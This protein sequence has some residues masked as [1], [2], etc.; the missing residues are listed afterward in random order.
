MLISIDTRSDL[1]DELRL[2]GEFLLKLGGQSKTEPLGSTLPEIVASRP[3]EAPLAEMDEPIDERQLDL[4]EPADPPEPEIDSEGVPWD[5][6]LH[7]DSKAK[8]VAGAWRK[9]RGRY[10][11]KN[12]DAV[13]AAMAAP[14]AIPSP[15]GHTMDLADLMDRVSGPLS[16]GRLV[17]S[18]V[19]DAI[20]EVGL[21]SVSDLET[22]PDL[23]P[24]V[25]ATI[26]GKIV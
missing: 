1:P 15:D 4:F 20:H 16:E 7:A 2:V 11:D 21:K 25:W 18:Q 10:A 22:R 19:F 8:N 6:R 12:A 14:A 3:Q 26:E 23:T 13:R 5:R 24:Q 17:M 9:R